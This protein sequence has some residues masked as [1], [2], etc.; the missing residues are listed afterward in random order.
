MWVGHF[1]AEIVAEKSD[2][3]SAFLM[4]IAGPHESAA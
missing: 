4:R 1:L 2:L 3:M